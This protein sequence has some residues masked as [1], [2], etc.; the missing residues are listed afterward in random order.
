L[1][2]TTPVAVEIRNS[3]VVT[4][5]GTPPDELSCGSASVATSATE[6]DVGNFV[7]GWFGNYNAGDFSLSGTG[8]TTFA[9]IAV[10]EAGDPATDID[11]D[12]RPDVDG[13]PDYA[14]ADVP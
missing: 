13:S 10:W 5:G 1:R 3:I 7:I 12:L 6:V 8:A 4:Q 2:C 11:G 9:D 14:G